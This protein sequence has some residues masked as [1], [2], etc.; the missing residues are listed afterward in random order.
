VLIAT[1]AGLECARPAPVRSV[2]MR[3][4]VWMALARAV[5]LALEEEPRQ[6]LL[7]QEAGRETGRE[8]SG[9]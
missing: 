8:L 3:F 9:D 4:D 7:G 5:P 1:D 6:G 2:P